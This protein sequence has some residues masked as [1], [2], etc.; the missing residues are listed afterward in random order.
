MSEVE[1]PEVAY[2]AALDSW[3]EKH[4]RRGISVLSVEAA[5]PHIARAAQVAIL[6]ERADWIESCN[7]D[8]SLMVERFQ[9]NI[10]RLMRKKAD[11]L[12]RG[13]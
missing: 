6:R 7:N 2:D 1:I 8:G 3:G 13:Q 5:A 11:E 4:S 10:V 9:H 12:E